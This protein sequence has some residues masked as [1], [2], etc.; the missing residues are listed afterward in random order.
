MKEAY[1]GKNNN[2]KNSS[3]WLW[4][5]PL[6]C[7][8]PFP[9][10]TSSASSSAY[11]KVY[12][13][14]SFY[15]LLFFSTSCVLHSCSCE[16]SRCTQTTPLQQA[17]REVRVKVPSNCSLGSAGA[18]LAQPHVLCLGN[19]LQSQS[20]H[21]RAVL[22]T[23]THSNAVDAPWEPSGLSGV[24]PA[25]WQLLGKRRGTY[26]PWRKKICISYNGPTMHNV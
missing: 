20:V 11:L 3:E 7:N 2:K 22:G 25:A 26:G 14:Q 1:N 24:T 18:A 5:Q 15:F 16:R 21:F 6:F 17:V 8:H 10:Q 12:S 23:R 13:L 4:H 9:K 19:M